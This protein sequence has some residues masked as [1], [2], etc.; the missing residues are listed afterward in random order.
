MTAATVPYGLVESVAMPYDETVLAVRDALAA[1]GFGVLTE[2][3]VRATLKKK[4]DLESWST[5][6]TVRAR[7]WWPFSIRKCSSG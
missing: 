5:P 6:A 2:I 3:D 1:E 7:A 4:L